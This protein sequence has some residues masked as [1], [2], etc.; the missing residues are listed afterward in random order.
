M[1]QR[2]LTE[3]PVWKALSSVSAPMSFGILAV[4]SIGVVDSYFL[5]RLGETP[6]AAIGFIFPVTTAFS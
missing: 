4:L 2:D 3:G 6:L 5:G 1:A